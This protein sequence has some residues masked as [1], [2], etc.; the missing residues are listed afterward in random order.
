MPDLEIEVLKPG[1]IGSTVLSGT[2]SIEVTLSSVLS[3]NN[4][5]SEIEVHEVSLPDELN[6]DGMVVNAG[7]APALMVLNVGD[8]VPV[9]I[10]VGTVILRKE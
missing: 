2:T 6:L 9:G 10:P 4:I 8:P 1:D 5:V 3:T 7:N